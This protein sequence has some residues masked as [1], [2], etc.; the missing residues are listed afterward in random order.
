M[1][2]PIAERVLQGSEYERARVRHLLLRQ[3]I[4]VKLRWQGRLL[5]AV[6]AV[7]PIV[8]SGVVDPAVRS[9]GGV[10]LAALLA[11]VATFGSGLGLSLVALRSRRRPPLA[12]RDARRLAVAE[13]VWSLVGFVS[14]GTATLATYAVLAGSVSPAAGALVTGPHRL[15]TTSLGLDVT[16]VATAALAGGVVLHVLGLALARRG[17]CVPARGGE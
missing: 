5:F 7:A 3:S 11:T 10:V 2:D 8:A 9:A 1:R 16:S 12:T 6:A 15:L 4:P 13:S 17:V 14:G